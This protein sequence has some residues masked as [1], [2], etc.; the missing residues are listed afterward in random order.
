M[1]GLG[2][3]L[4]TSTVFNVFMISDVRLPSQKCLETYVKEQKRPAAPDRTN[5]FADMSRPMFRD[6][7]L[8]S[9]G[10][11]LIFSNSLRR[12][13]FSQITLAFWKIINK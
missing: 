12:V 13:P 1:Q 2:L 7:T 3:L 9:S 6:S 11:E 8:K 5:E 4:S 10:F